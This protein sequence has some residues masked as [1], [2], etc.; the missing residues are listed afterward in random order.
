MYYTPELS[1]NT[2]D[3]I[4]NIINKLLH[5]RPTPTII[6]YSKFRTARYTR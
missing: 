5:Q 2:H 1:L 4:N 6:S 3:D